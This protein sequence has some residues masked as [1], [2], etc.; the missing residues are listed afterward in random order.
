MEQIC[1]AAHICSI[2]THTHLS[3][4]FFRSNR[5]PAGLSARARWV[6]SSSKLCVL[7]PFS[8][9]IAFQAMVTVLAGV[10]TLEVTSGGVLS[11]NRCNPARDHGRYH[12]SRNSRI[13]SSG[14]R[15]GYTSVVVSRS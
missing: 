12:F 9:R 5:V 15:L 4:W 7:D 14:E 8:G 6:H 13:T 2:H 1:A 3:E 11:P 10:T